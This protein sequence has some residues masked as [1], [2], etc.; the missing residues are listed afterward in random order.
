M[1]RIEKYLNPDAKSTKELIENIL[2]KATD[3][4]LM[5]IGHLCSLEITR[6][7]EE[8]RKLNELEPLFADNGKT[9]D[10]YQTMIDKQHRLPPPTEQL[11]QENLKEL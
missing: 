4:Q 11:I 2:Q 6:R 3:K 5:T 10:E 1:D 8:T 9:N 7:T